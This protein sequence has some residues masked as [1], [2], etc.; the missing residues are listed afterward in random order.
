GPVAL[1]DDLQIH[2]DG[3]AF[4]VL[5][6]ALPFLTAVAPQN[7]DEIRELLQVSGPAQ[8]GHSGPAAPALGRLALEGSVE[9]C[10]AQHRDLKSLGDPVEHHPALARLD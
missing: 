1:L 6:L 3:L 2:R 9:L 4:L 8:V 5:G 10:Q 7:S